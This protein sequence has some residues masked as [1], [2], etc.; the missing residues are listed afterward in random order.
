[1]DGMSCL[2]NLLLLIWDLTSCSYDIPTVMEQILKLFNGKP[3]LIVGFNVFLPPGY[4]IS[5]EGA[6]AMQVQTPTDVNKP[7]PSSRGPETSATMA[8]SN[9]QKPKG[10]V[11]FMEA[12]NFVNIVKSRYHSDP[13]VYK[14]F[15]EDLQT[16]Q[17][18]SLP[19]PVV[20]ARMEVLFQSHPDLIEEF[21]RFMPAQAAV[22]VPM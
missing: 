3:D 10:P 21:D 6:N 8:E 19:V 18:E 12:I 7:Q 1:M 16:Y 17:R 4:K 13:D 2:D 9:G 22:S 15:L 20:R 14:M 5:Y 11:E